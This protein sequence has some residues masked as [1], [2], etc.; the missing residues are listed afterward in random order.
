MKQVNMARLPISNDD[1]GLISAIVARSGVVNGQRLGLELMLTTIHCLYPL[2]LES[3][4]HAP[5]N[6]FMHDLQ[7]IVD[8]WNT[9]E[10]LFDNLFWPRYARDD[11]DGF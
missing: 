7:G 10:L 6:H 1:A 2:E 5:H 3:L 9:V 8:N 4:L 11:G